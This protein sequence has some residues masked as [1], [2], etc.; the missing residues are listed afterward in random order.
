MRRKRVVFSLALVTLL[1]VPLGVLGRVQARSPL[2]GAD[3]VLPFARRSRVTQAFGGGHSG[4]DYRADNGVPI[5]AAK[6]GQVTVTHDDHPDNWC[7]VPPPFDPGNYVYIDHLAGGYVTR[8]FHLQHHSFAVGVGDY[9]S[10][11]QRIANADT[12]GTTGPDANHYCNPPAAHLH[13][14]F[15]VNGNPT[16][17]Y[18]GSTHW[19]GSD[20][21]PMGYRDQNGAVHGPFPLDNV[22]IRNR[23]VTEARKLGSPITNDSSYPCLAEGLQATG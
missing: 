7:V 6:Y 11:G 22:K 13:F 5:S 2:A 20:P 17:P 14:Q 9:V 8:Y 18:A 10:P 21:F 12:T 15:E 1:L 3:L 16:D 4:T 19:A 23:W